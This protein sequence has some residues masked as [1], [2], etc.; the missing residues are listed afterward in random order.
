MPCQ[1]VVVQ[2]QGFQKLRLTD[3]VVELLSCKLSK[4]TLG[5]IKQLKITVF[6]A[7]G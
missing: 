3:S 6:M 1:S 2:D 5:D 7:D 4:L